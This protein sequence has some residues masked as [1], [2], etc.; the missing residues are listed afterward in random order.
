MKKYLHLFHIGLLTLFFVI[1]V[2]SNW[3]QNRIIDELT[4][5]RL[6]DSLSSLVEQNESSVYDWASWD[7]TV[8][9]VSQKNKNYF[10]ENFN[11]DTARVLQLAIATDKNNVAIAGKR[12]NEEIQEFESLN[13]QDFANLSPNLQECG[14]SFTTFWE[15]NYLISS[16][17]ISPTIEGKGNQIYGCLFRTITPERQTSNDFCQSRK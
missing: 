4:V 5:S 17:F 2:H 14:S 3:I 7:E 8:D 11:Q 6:K 13:T 1:S 12:W 9:L 16:S 10:D 15:G